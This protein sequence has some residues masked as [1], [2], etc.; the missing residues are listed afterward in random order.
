MA[1][2]GVNHRQTRLAKRGLKLGDNRDA[3]RDLAN[4]IAERFR[5][6]F[7]RQKSRCMSMQTR[8]M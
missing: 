6:P 8:A 3:G 4:V 2:L 5:K 7:G 1:L